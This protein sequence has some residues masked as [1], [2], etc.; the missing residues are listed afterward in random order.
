MS[1]IKSVRGHSCE[2]LVKFQKFSTY[3]CIPSY[4]EDGTISGCDGTNEIP[5]LYCPFCGDKLK[6]PVIYKHTCKDCGEEW[7]DVINHRECPKCQGSYS[8][9]VEKVECE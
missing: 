6:S 8:I 7:S 1:D 3:S 2:G 9:K 5:I 4:D